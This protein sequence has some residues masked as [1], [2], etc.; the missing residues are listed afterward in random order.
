[1]KELAPYLTAIVAALLLSS[2]ATPVCAQERTWISQT[3]SDGNISTNCGASKPCQTFSAALSVTSPG[4][5]VNCIGP[6]GEFNDATA[7][8]IAQ[9]VTIDCHGSFGGLEKNTNNGFVINA[10]GAVVTLRGLNLNGLFGFDGG[11]AAGDNGVVIQAAAVVNIEDCVIDNF[12][13]SGIN[14]Q[15]TGGGQL[16]IGNTVLRNNGGSSGSLSSG[17]YIVPGSGMTATVSID[18]SQINGNYFGIVGD[19]RSGGIIKGTIKDSVVSGNTENGITALS[20]GSSVLFVLDQTEVSANAA[21]GLFANGSGSGVL[22]RN[23]TV[24]DNGVGLDAA[25]G[26]GLVSYGNNSVAG[27]TTNGAFTATVGLQ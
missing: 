15:R 11:P 1:M 22:A 6:V 2:Y 12:A 24:F 23:T 26:G 18:H 19:G 20:S 16:F 13:Q 8:N 9:A 14:D 7:I 27:N 21:A 17:I 25:S 4:G 10:S 5:E 3:G